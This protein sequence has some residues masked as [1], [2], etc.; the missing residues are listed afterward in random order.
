GL[1]ILPRSSREILAE[2]SVVA[3]VIDDPRFVRPIALIKKR[4]RT[5]P[6]VSEAFVA[7]ISPALEQT[8]AAKGR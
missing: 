6:P 3:R 1:T 2:S 4:G 8:K 7:A 5:L